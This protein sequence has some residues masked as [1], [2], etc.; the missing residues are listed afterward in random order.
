MHTSNQRCSRRRW[1]CFVS[2]F[3]PFLVLVLVLCSRVGS[4]CLVAHC[5]RLQTFVGREAWS[6]RFNSDD[7]EF[8]SLLIKLNLLNILASKHTELELAGLPLRVD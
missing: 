3:M 1:S 8:T 2:I 5:H 6:R 7:Q 4:F